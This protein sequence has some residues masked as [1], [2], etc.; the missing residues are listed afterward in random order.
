M[1]N[2]KI[3]LSVV[4]EISIKIIEHIRPVMDRAEI[5]GSIRRRKQ[6]V[7]DVEICGF[8]GDREKLIQLLCEDWPTY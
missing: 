4:D 8:P 1:S 7:E 2:G 6:V 5:A 3:D